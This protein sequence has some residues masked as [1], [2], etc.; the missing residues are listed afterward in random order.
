[1]SEEEVTGEREKSLQDI[2][3]EAEERACAV[4]RVLYF[5]EQ[6]LSG[7][8]CGRC[9]PCA[10]GSYEARSRIGRFMR[11]S[12]KA[13]SADIEVL[14]RIGTQMVEGSRCKKGKDTGKFITDTVN[15]AEQEITEH[16]FGRCPQRECAELV[17]FVITPGL[18]TACGK[19]AEA[20]RYGAIIGEKK[21]TFLAGYLPFEIR[22][23]RCTKCG[24]CVKVC[25]TGAVEIVSVKTDELVNR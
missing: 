17:E 19:C 5:L 25:P 4:Q 2:R 24:E 9:F 11:R 18:C 15:A 12:G 8:M 10:F 21:K 22:Q 23:K 6:F 3:K 13:G 14:K 7:P 16:I 20:C 1:M